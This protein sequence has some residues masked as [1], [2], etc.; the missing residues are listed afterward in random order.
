MNPM[1]AADTLPLIAL[2]AFLWI[3]CWAAILWPYTG[4]YN[5]WLYPGYVL[6]AIWCAFF[7]N[8]WLA[9]TVIAVAAALMLLAAVLLRRRE[10]R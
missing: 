5:W 8:G 9:W 6:G 7:W 1:N 4:K 10:K 2:P 3:G